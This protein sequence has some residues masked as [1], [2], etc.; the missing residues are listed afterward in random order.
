MQEKQIKA[1]K[2]ECN[3]KVLLLYFRN[4]NLDHFTAA[5]RAYGGDFKQLFKRGS[6]PQKWHFT[7]V[8]R[9]TFRILVGDIFEIF[10]YSDWELASPCQDKSTAASS[11]H[12]DMMFLHWCRNMWWPSSFLQAR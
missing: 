3:A 11:G 1:K 12:V 6:S 2:S 10:G 9:I 4:S 7:P 8:V 5:I